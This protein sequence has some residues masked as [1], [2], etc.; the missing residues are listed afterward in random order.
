MHLAFSF[1]VF[2]LPKCTKTKYL[3]YY[4]LPKSGLACPPVVP[5][6]LT[7]FSNKYQLKH[8]GIGTSQE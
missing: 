4:F 7:M 3:M 8:G 5:L 2:T 1:L 6:G